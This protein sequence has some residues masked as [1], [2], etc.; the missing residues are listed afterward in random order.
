MD[1]FVR[2]VGKVYISGSRN[3]A[4]RPRRFPFELTGLLGQGGQGG[5]FR[6]RCTEECGRDG[7]DPGDVVALKIIPVPLDQADRLL[8]R[9]SVRMRALG[10]LRSPAIV[11]HF[12]CLA[13][14]A[15]PTGAVLV[16]VM[17]LAEGRLLSDALRESSAGMGPA[18]ALA[19]ARQLVGAFVEMESGG[20]SHCDIQPSN[21]VLAADGTPRLIDFGL[22]SIPRARRPLSGP[23]PSEGRLAA[24]RGAFDFM[25]P[26]FIRPFRPRPG[27]CGDSLS[28]LF[29]FCVLVHK[30]AV[31]RL[32]YADPLRDR[33]GYERRW[34]GPTDFSAIRVDETGLAP[35]SGLAGVLR[36]GLAPD[37]AARIPSF[38]VLRS[39]LDA[40]LP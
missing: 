7:V 34:F 35:V 6:A 39:E 32:P 25:A 11:R 38:R 3:C 28:D 1:C 5:V 12:G 36:R 37:R 9:L 40:V 19:L 31:G 24:A 29:S 14:A 18:A 8:S 17:G 16:S 22:A 27:F 21:V 30:T 10:R 2:P 4:S 23:A 26:D 15:G 20:I 13:A 33:A